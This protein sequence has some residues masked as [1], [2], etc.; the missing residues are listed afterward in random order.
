LHFSNPSA[1]YALLALP[2]ILLIHFLQERSRRV[3]VSTLFLLEHAAPVSIG[4]ARFERLRNSLPLWLQL[5]AA[6]IVTWLLAE[7]RWTRQDSRQSIA[8]VLDSSI[9]MSAF[10]ENLEPTLSKALAPWS[11]AATTTDWLLT[12]SDTRLPTLYKGTDLT[13]LLDTLQSFSPSQ[14]THDPTNALLLARSLVK[15]TGTVLFITDHRPATLPSDTGLIALGTPIPNIGFAGLTTTSSSS[16]SSSSPVEQ[17]AGLPPSSN[18]PAAYSVLV[19]NPSPT[20]QTR[21]WWTELPQAPPGSQFTAKQ[22]L[23]LAPGQSI[24]LSGTFPPNLDQVILYLTPDAFPIDDIL[25]IRRPQPRRLL[26]EIR[27]PSGPTRQL[28]T[29]LL[30]SLENLNLP[31]ISPSSSPVEQAAGLP[32]TSR[33]EAAPPDLLITELGE[34]VPTHAIQFTAAGTGSTT[35]LDPAPVVADNHPFTRDLDWASLLTPTPADLTL[36][37][38]DQPLLWKG[39][40]PLALLRQD[41]Q[42]DGTRTQRLLLAWNPADSSAARNP[43]ILIL[44]H[45][46]TEH[47]RTQKRAFHADNFETHQPLN[48]PSPPKSPR[49][50]TTPVERAAGSPPLSITTAPDTPTFFDLHEGD[51][52]LLSAAAHFGDTRESDFTKSET[53]DETA[54]LRRQSTL[55]QTE[56]DPLTPLY[57]LA[58]ISL[59]LLS[60][61]RTP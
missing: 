31:T 18:G 22:S 19:R 6:L 20:P 9:S 30:T 35:A 46:F 32:P 23:T 21:E 56:A 55:K 50:L 57:L 43:A 36:A 44:L 39:G 17:A 28:F 54:A 15:A 53:L 3:R 7:P 47:L 59:L 13:A 16:S 34:S 25:P 33:G 51:T 58:L 24:T 52:H 1:L 14:G 42:D 10:Q 60:W 61:T 49:T 41:T 2:A 37:D 26:A 40:K 48:L 45:R 8:V 38:T 5:L 12:L 4:G 11:R 27:L 29:T